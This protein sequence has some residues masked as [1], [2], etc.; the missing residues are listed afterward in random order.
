[1]D[2]EK[3][4]DKI[5][6]KL[7]PHTYQIYGIFDFRSKELIYVNLDYEDVELQFELAGYGDGFDI[8]KFS[9]VVT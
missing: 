7:Q 8:I 5:L 9:V 2:D 6:K 3:S 1:M 4:K